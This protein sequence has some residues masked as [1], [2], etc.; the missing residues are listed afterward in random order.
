MQHSNFQAGKLLI[1]VHLQGSR[2]PATTWIF[3]GPSSQVPLR[4]F[5]VPGPFLLIILGS[6]VLSPPRGHS[7]QVSSSYIF[8]RS[9][10][11]LGSWYA[12][13]FEN[14]ALSREFELYFF[15]K[16]LRAVYVYVFYIFGNCWDSGT[17]R[18]CVS[19]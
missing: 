17:L 19:K 5:Q 3:W 15:S 14:A 6:W 2:V 12:F 10:G 18:F 1:N 7:S 16:G 4:G 9:A 13:S 11:N 8:R